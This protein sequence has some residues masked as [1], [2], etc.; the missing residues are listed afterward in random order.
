MICRSSSST[1]RRHRP[2]PGH[3]HTHWPVAAPG[4]SGASLGGTLCV[5][6]IERERETMCVCA[7]VGV[8]VGDTKLSTRRRIDLIINSFEWYTYLH[9]LILISTDF[10]FRTGLVSV[11]GLSRSQI[12]NLYEQRIIDS[13]V[14]LSSF[15]SV[16]SQSKVSQ[17]S[18]KS[19][20][21]VQDQIVF[22]KSWSD[23]AWL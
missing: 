17:K 16:K 12:V 19:Q 4:Q 18:T 11:P 3:T 2:G 21:K 23:R 5:S 9:I 22:V 14:L 6:D 8:G 20:S 13:S 7:G 15:Q 1:D 10:Q